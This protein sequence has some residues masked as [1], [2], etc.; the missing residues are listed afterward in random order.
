[1]GGWG[2]QTASTPT[3]G[4][5]RLWFGSHPRNIGIAAGPSGLLIIDEDELDALTLAADQHGETLPT[6]YRVL[7]ARGWHW[8]FA[9]PDNEFG[10]GAGALA[11][12]GCDVRGGN[13]AGGYVVAAGSLHASGVHYVAEDD[14][15]DIAPLP[16]WI[17]TLLRTP[18][19]TKAA[20]PDSPDG[21]AAVPDGGWTD[22]PR[23]GLPDELTEQYGRHLAAV[24][25]PGGEFRHQLFLAA[26]DGWRL[27]DIG[28]LDELTML[29]QIRE[30]IV[31]VWAAE[32][33]DDD[34]HIVYS[35]AREKATASPWRVLDPLDG[36]SGTSPPG[37]GEPADAYELAVSAKLRELQVL[38]EA[39]RR[40]ARAQR[41]QRPAIADGVL[42]DLDAIP[43]PEMLMGSLIPEHAVGF[44]AGRSGAYKSFL[45]VS[46]ACCVATGRPWLGDHRFRVRHPLRTLYVAAEG[47]S[48]AAGRIRAWEAANGDTRK[49]RMLLYPRAIHLNDPAQVDEL[50][51]YVTEHGIQF[52]VIDTYHRSA[53][54]TEEN[55]STDF[56]IV[57]EAVARLRDD[58]G[59]ATL[60]VDHTGAGKTGNPRGTSAKRDDAD[61]VLSAT[62]LGEEAAPDAQR[63]L[64]V[65]K[66]KDEDTAGRWP[67]L[68]AEVPGQRFPIVQIG[69]VGD[70]EVIRNL[71]EW[72]TPENCPVVPDDVVAAI[73]N[74]AD[75][76]GQRGRG[77]EQ[78][79]W[80]WRLL[81]AVDDDQGLTNGDVRKMLL[82]AGP[83]AVHGDE[84]V[85]R[86]IALLAK[87]RFAYRPTRSSIALE[88][89][90][91]GGA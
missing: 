60:F 44:L 22:E 87:T 79:K 29:R 26:L 70:S 75:Q 54:G 78:A 12:Y 91:G 40:L 21:P 58:A 81:A 52:L 55:S 68:L 50:A 51:A 88:P 59:C 47:S 7:T 27:V 41:A 8:Y 33:D 83:T 66:L 5:L 14:H 19:T 23:Y 32:P 3:D 31:R 10:N 80:V 43:E 4:M 11:D 74:E 48:G 65:T 13:G 90:S 37:P 61:Y 53:P 77:I 67:I 56:S 9:D 71:R 25:T 15:A 36:A 69:V 64:F 35:E 34:R 39:R 62:Y 84:L 72:W 46:W 42:D 16:D 6:T 63:E 18:S 86:G 89:V 38:D 20:A 85:K 45:A 1:V 17:K 30:A 82:A 2:T 76:E 57:F 28:L 73:T 24:R 49:G